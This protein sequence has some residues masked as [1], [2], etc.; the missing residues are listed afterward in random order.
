MEQCYAWNSSLSAYHVSQ[1]HRGI[2][3]NGSENEPLQRVE[4]S[5]SVSEW[6]HRRSELS[7]V[8]RHTMNH[9]HFLRRVSGLLQK[10]LSLP[11]TTLAVSSW[12]K[13]W[14][15]THKNIIKDWFAPDNMRRKRKPIENPPM[16]QHF[17]VVLR[18]DNEHSRNR[19]TS[20]WTT[21]SRERCK[22][23]AISRVVFDT[24]RTACVL[25]ASGYIRS[26]PNCHLQRWF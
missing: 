4:S 2:N 20:P 24:H 26:C 7:Y 14:A 3:T 5:D 23:C 10:K 9:F 1:R 22:F 6:T 8:L 12:M 18:N 21:S 13:N 25:G 17:Q 16:P 15:L 11:G 19:W